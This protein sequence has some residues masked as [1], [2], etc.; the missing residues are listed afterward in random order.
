MPSFKFVLFFFCCFFFI[1]TNSIIIWIECVNCRQSV[2]L[3]VYTHTHSICIQIA[4]REISL[5]LVQFYGLVVVVSNSWF[6]LKHNGKKRRCTH[7]YTKCWQKETKVLVNFSIFFCFIKKNFI[8][9]NYK[10]KGKTVFSSK[11]MKKKKAFTLVFY[12]V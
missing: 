8:T 6:R 2:L 3:V 5:C 9:L 11:Q 12:P 4:N 7:E 10:I 1:P